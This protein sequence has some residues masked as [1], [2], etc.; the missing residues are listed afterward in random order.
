MGSIYLFTPY[1]EK[2]CCRQ[3]GNGC[4]RHR[5]TLFSFD[6]SLGLGCLHRCRSVMLGILNASRVWGR[7]AGS[8]HSHLPSVWTVPRAVC[9]QAPLLWLMAAPGLAVGASCPWEGVGARNNMRLWYLMDFFMY[10]D[11]AKLFGS[12]WVLVCCK[13]GLF[14]CRLKPKAGKRSQVWVWFF[15]PLLLRKLI[16]GRDVRHRKWP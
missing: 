16:L 12:L 14:W 11:S 2:N 9:E 5:K 10:I 13:D 7:P 3:K 4:P 1:I 8:A 15:F 6:P